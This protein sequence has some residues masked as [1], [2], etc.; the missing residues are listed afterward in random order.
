MFLAILC[1][2]RVWRPVRWPSPG[3]AELCRGMDGWEVGGKSRWASLRRQ[4]NVLQRSTGLLQVPAHWQSS[5]LHHFLLQGATVEHLHLIMFFSWGEGVQGA[6]QKHEVLATEI[7]ETFSNKKAAQRTLFTRN[8]TTYTWGFNPD[9]F[10][11]K[12][13]LA[14][15][16]PPFLFFG[17]LT[18]YPV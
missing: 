4:T 10:W 15:V 12:N 17:L 3:S 2:T 6:Q 18:N 16:M 11:D 14:V 13:I 8:I 9:Y 5:T 7:S 1:W